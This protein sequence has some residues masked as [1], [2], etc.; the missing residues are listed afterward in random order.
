[1]LFVSLAAKFATVWHE[2]SFVL[3]NIDRAITFLASSPVSCACLKTTLWAGSASTY[4]Q[5][6]SHYKLADPV[7]VVE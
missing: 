1:M 4:A 7:Q 5:Y 2:F 3:F 6:V